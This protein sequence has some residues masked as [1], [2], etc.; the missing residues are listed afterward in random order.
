MS[1]TAYYVGL[2]VGGTT[3]KAAVVDDAGTV[4][5]TAT[6]STEAHKGQEHGLNQMCATIRKAVEVSKVGIAHVAAIGVAT[7]GTMDIPNGI[8]LDPPNL[9]PWQNVPVRAHVH[10]VFNI[11][12]AF[13]N[14]ANAAAYGEYWVGAGRDV[15]SM[16]MFTLGTGIGGGIIIDD[17]VMEGQH[18]HGGEVGHMKIQMTP[19]G[20]L[21]G[22]GRRGCLEAYASATSVVKRA[23][24]ALAGQSGDSV[25]KTLLTATDEELPAKVVFQ[26]ADQG[27][28]TAKKIVDDTAFYL[29]VGAMNIMHLIDPDMIVYAGGMTAA[30]EPFLNRI[31][32]YIRELAF[33]V[34]AAKT[35]VQYATLGSDAGFI[36]AAACA[37]QL[38][39][40]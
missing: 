28:A 5:G 40:K 15:K 32:H 20:R 8:I 35:I 1:S 33:P 38:A 24:E 26:A 4:F 39:K 22:C 18:S 2:D 6:M 25:L 3:M 19:D 10:G 14:D 37:R 21:C 12:T 36:G 27:D 9:K 30:G 34:P 31:K 13:Q 16:V 11:P 23:Q 17:K 7:P 29:A